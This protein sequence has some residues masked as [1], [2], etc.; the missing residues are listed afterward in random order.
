MTGG[1]VLV[2]RPLWPVLRRVGSALS[3]AGYRVEESASW[4]RL[5]ESGLSCRELSG[6]ILGETGNAREEIEIVRRFRERDGALGVPLVLVGGMNAIVRRGE[7]EAAGIDI[8]VAADASAGEIVERIRPLL[9]YGSL[10][11]AVRDEARRARERSLRD[12]LTGLPDRRHF[13]LDLARNVELARR[14]GRPLSCIIIDIDDFRRVNERY[15]AAAG[16]GLIRQVAK[17]LE[18]SSRRYDAL[19]RLGGDE[20]GWLLVDADAGNA[21]RVARRAHAMI[22]GK[23]FEGGPEPVHVTATIGVSSLAPGEDPTASD[24][25][26]NAD[27]ALYWGKESGKNAVRFYPA[28][29]AGRG[30]AEDDRHIS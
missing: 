26:G 29:A 27:R 16:D 3:S 19:A 18:G 25:V 28:G 8:V 15:G 30:D 6:V 21:V 13:S 7:F 10:Y 9:R 4:A 5:L 22:A 1:F 12:E 23:A 24:L 17:T 2:A 14:T 11:Q 20:F